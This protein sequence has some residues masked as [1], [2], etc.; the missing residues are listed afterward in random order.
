MQRHIA[1]FALL[2]SALCI[3]AARAEDSGGWQTIAQERGIL[4]STREEP[5]R[6]LPSFRGQA[7]VD[8]PV[9]HLLAILLD[10]EHSNEWAKG[11]DETSILRSVN[12]RT[13]IIYARARQPWPVKDRDVVMRRTVDVLKP[14]EMF[15][16]HLT[17][18]PNEKPRVDGVVR[19]QKC[20][21]TFVL[22]AIDATHTSIDYRVNADP[23]GQNPAW[24][25]RMASKSIPLD[26]LVGLRKQA[27]RTRGKYT[28]AV[29]TWS[30]AI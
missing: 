11:A 22:H 29:A 19:V 24:I 20:E 1:L 21:T 4:V 12:D 2:S 5:G 10:D 17:C 25:V 7:K 18:A 27:A 9:L 13:Q 14:G 30:K 23:G 8:A 26:T 6:E 28:E 16:V 15:R 3:G